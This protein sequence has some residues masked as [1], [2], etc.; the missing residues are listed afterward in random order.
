MYSLDDLPWNNRFATLSKDFYAA[1]KPTALKNAHW[2]S[3]NSDAAQLINLSPE[4]IHNSDFLAFCAGDRLPEAC[5]PLA[6][7]Y[8]GH[9]FGHYVSQLGDGRAIMLGES[10]GWELQLKGSG[11]TPF[12]RSA[13]GRA[14]LRS[15]IREYLC[16]E[17][18][19]H[20]GIP[21]TRALAM[22]NSEEEVCRERIETG[23]MLLRMAPSHIRF[24][25]FEVFFHRRQLDALHQLAEFVKTHY[26][27]EVLDDPKPNLALLNMI[28]QRTAKLMAQWQLVGFAHGVM[29][30]D[31]MSILGLT[32]D[33]G[34]FGFLDRYNPHFICNH[35]D[36]A[37]R[38]AFDQQPSIGLWNLN[39]LAH[40]MLPLLSADPDQ[41]VEQ[42][43]S[44]LQG[45]QG[46]YEQAWLQGCRA[47]LG[48]YHTEINASTD[49]TSKLDTDDTEL[50]KTLLNSL[51]K[52]QVD[53]T[54]FFRVLST[55]KKADSHD[56]TPIRDL[57]LDRNDFDHW[58]LQYR[59]RLEHETLSDTQRQTKM[60]QVNPKYILRNYM[61]ET[62][63]QQ[64]E[65][66][67]YAEVEHLLKLLQSPYDEQINNEH[68]AAEPPQWA[69]EISVSCSS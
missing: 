61:A 13:D 19:H 51:H 36:H 62:A 37:G 45:Y 2:V 40:A 15:T 60:N 7:L 21:T 16:S 46:E 56:D 17:A 69:Q 67:D 6:M 24:G 68:Y 35:S 43:K 28:V 42:A 14:V 41:A 23:A 52:N 53:Y 33:Y 50:M 5:Q 11:E 64:A 32:L 48:L 47:K 22:V 44:A 65:Q 26:Y 58:A 25:S 57:F 27:P 20:L 54:R 66:G 1:V 38:Y 9:Q 4:E 55:L 31:N 10:Q 59:L 63:I 34:P 30:T 8:S 39:C 12:S 49:N 3:F 29:N 18:M